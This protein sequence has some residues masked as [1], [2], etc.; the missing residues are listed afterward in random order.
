[1]LDFSFSVDVVGMTNFAADDFMN[2]SPWLIDTIVTRGGCGY[3]VDSY[4]ADSLQ[5]WIC[6]DNGGEPLC[7]PP[8]DGSAYWSITLS[9]FDPQV[10][11]GF[12]EPE[13]VYLSLDT[14]I[15]LSLIHI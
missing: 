12:L 4:N 7:T 14:P 10:G 13:D 8:Y 5:W 3:Y 9:P 6:P 1:M 15:S 2:I 11:L